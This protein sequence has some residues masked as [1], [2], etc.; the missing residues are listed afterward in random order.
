M[1]ALDELMRCCRE[2]NHVLTYK[3]LVALQRGDRQL[4]ER[5]GLLYVGGSFDGELGDY[6]LVLDDAAC[7]K[8]NEREGAA[9]RESVYALYAVPE[10][11]PQ[12]DPL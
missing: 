4:T 11:A 9:G 1:S 7:D 10:T 3:D 8:I 2:D 6:D 12:K 5:V